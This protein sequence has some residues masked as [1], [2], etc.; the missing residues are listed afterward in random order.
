[1]NCKINVC[2]VSGAYPLVNDGIADYTAK[3]ID[4]L[5]RGNLE[6]SLITSDEEAIRRHIKEKNPCRVYPVIKKWNIFAVIAVLK[7]IRKEKFDI[8][9]L[10]YPSSRYK[11]TFFLCFLPFFVRVFFRN[12]KMV[13]TLHE[14]FISH[15]INKLRQFLLCLGSHKVIVTDRNDLEQLGR[16]LIQGRK[17]MTVIP[18][19]SNIDVCEYNPEE[20]RV[21]LKKL[22]LAEQAKII[23]FFGFIHQ[24]KG[25]ECLLKAMRKVIDNGVA[26]QLLFISQLNSENN[27][28]HNRIRKLIDSLG[29]NSSIFITGYVA[30]QEISKFLSLSDICVLPFGDGVTLRRGTLMAALAHARPVIST[31]SYKYIP[32]ELIDKENIY[33]IPI[34]DVEKLSEAIELLCVDDELRKKIAEGAGRAAKEFSWSKIAEH[35]NI[36]YQKVNGR[37]R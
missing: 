23:V 22:G 30:P 34:N 9:H 2:F 17:K 8:V 27:A 6:I 25:I 11:K 12:T 5:D 37:F 32:S 13:V 24:N 35:H 16:I 18:I 20:K 1:M 4:N 10:Q 26:A 36:L 3:L 19:G 7:L 28:Y 33:L 14:F 21:F 29:I 31:K 15:P